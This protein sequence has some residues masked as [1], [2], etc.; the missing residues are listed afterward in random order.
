MARIAKRKN[1][2]VEIA[3]GEKARKAGAAYEKDTER[4][5]RRLGGIRA[6]R[7]MADHYINNPDEGP[8]MFYI[9]QEAYVTYAH[10]TGKVDFVIYI[11]DMVEVPEFSANKNG[12]YTAIPAECKW[13]QSEGTAEDKLGM[14]CN[15][16]MKM[17]GYDRSFLI[18][19]LSGVSFAG[20]RE[21]AYFVCEA[22]VREGPGGHEQVVCSLPEAENLLMQMLGIIPV[23]ERCSFNLR[24]ERDLGILPEKI[25]YIQ[26]SAGMLQ[27]MWHGKPLQAAQLD[28]FAN[29]A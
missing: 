27:R 12:R 26:A 10:K 19:H 21:L 11:R 2:I 29:A 4:M 18:G 7:K 16:L 6:S 15:R 23:E 25:D 3:G 13:Q 8:Q 22:V 14:S 5:L 24:K 20:A 17:R 9:R 28:L 1:N